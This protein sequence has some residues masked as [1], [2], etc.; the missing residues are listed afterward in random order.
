MDRGPGHFSSHQHV[1]AHVLDRLEA[2]DGLA[3]LVPFLG[4]GDC[5]VEAL[6][7]V[8]HLQRGREDGAVAKKPTAGVLHR[9]ARPATWTAATAA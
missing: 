5:E 3:E 4:V 1:G 6:G 7:R 2:A 9:P 8:A